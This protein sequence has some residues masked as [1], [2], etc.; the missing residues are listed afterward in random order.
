MN[1]SVIIE[2]N[3]RSPKTDNSGKIS[4]IVPQGVDLKIEIE[5][6]SIE[7]KE[8]SGIEKTYF[9]STGLNLQ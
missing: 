8:Y 6:I 5:D 2:I 1:M 7:G 4:L 9:S 3:C